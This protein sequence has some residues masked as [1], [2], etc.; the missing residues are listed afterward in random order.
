M[1]PKQ[2][3]DDVVREFAYFL[4]T[5]ETPFY[6]VQ[7]KHLKRSFA[8]LGVSLPDEKVFRTTYLDKIHVEVREA[9]SSTLAK[10]FE[11]CSWPSL[12]VHKFV[13]PNTLFFSRVVGRSASAPMA[14]ST[15]IAP[16]GCL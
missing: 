10:V 16:K 6:R 14:G 1:V 4:Y 9:A 3:H 11:V 12:H 8:L 2:K 5:S 15:S 13:Y 7:N